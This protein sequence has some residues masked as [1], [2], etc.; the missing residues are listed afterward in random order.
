MFQLGQ[1]VANGAW[2]VLSGLAF[3][4]SRS[5]Q[6]ATTARRRAPSRKRRTLFAFETIHTL[7]A[8]CFQRAGI[9][10]YP[11]GRAVLDV[12][13]SPGVAERFERLDRLLAA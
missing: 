7:R 11:Q 6:R 2:Q 8:L 12:G 13:P 10:A 1:Y 5:F 3:N 9:L 4:L